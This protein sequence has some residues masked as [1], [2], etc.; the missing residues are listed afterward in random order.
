[1]G[2][3]NDFVTSFFH[4][5]LSSGTCRTPGLS[6]PCCCLSTSSSVCLVFFPLSPCLARWFWPD[7]MNGRHDHTTAVC[8]SLQ[9]SKGLRV[10]RLPA[11]PWHGLPDRQIR[12]RSFHQPTKSHSHGG[13]IKR[14]VDCNYGRLERTTLLDR[15][16]NFVLISDSLVFHNYFKHLKIEAVCSLKKKSGHNSEATFVSGY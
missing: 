3:T 14:S 5:S 6:I 13:Q 12:H 10:V 11:G 16:R 7:L 1:M 9:R 15:K 8:V 2:T 4:F